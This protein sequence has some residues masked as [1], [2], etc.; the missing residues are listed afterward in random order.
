MQGFWMDIGQPKDYIAGEL[1]Y[2]LSDDQTADNQEPV[3]T[4][5]T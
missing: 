5:H 4:C 1:A 2:T 3:Y